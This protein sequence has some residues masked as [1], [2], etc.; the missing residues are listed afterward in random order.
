MAL[1]LRICLLINRRS[2][3]TSDAKT[4]N[5]DGSRLFIPQHDYRRVYARIY[6]GPTEEV[7]DISMSNVRVIL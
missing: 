1:A 6:V 4:A 2:N 3:A 7:P 5:R